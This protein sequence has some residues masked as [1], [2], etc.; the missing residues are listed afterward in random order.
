MGGHSNQLFQYATGRRL[1]HKHKTELVLDHSWFDDI[2]DTD[3]HRE[4]ELGDYPVAARRATKSDIG[5]VMDPSA[6]VS[7][8]S[9]AA[10]RIRLD[11][12]I[13]VFGEAHGGFNRQVLSLPD[14]TMLIGWWQSER[15]FKDIRNIL[16]KELEPKYPINKQNQK[17]LTQIKSTTSV[18]LHVRR[19]DY[20]DNKHA[21]KFH[22]LASVDYY[23]K[24]V[25]HV[26]NQLG[27]DAKLHVFVFSNDVDWCRK[28]LSFKYPVTF[29]TGNTN[30]ADDMRL[31][32]HCKHNI[33]ANSSFSWW[34]AWL[35]ENPSKIIIAPRVWFQD[36]TANAQTDIVPEAWVRL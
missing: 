4:Y 26:A 5:K 31:M 22:G 17:Y 14:N 25:A 35:N 21:N 33:L 3:T 1:A 2:P 7:L 23:R 18:S 19:G 10:R 15:Y 28:N 30:G 12:S 24:A 34:G 20:V 8:L 32:K 9:K 29:V 6:P 11:K 13:R 27:K 16:V 36:K